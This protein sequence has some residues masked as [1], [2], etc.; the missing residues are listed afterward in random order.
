MKTTI[1]LILSKETKNTIVYKADAPEIISSVYVN[2][3]AFAG[4]TT[5]DKITLTIEW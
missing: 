3:V 2:K 5:P 4:A 1:T